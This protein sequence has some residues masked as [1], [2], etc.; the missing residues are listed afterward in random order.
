MEPWTCLKVGEGQVDDAVKAPGAR[1]GGVQGS[2]P[3]GGRHDDDTRV[4]L[5]AVHL[6]QQLID[7]LHALCRCTGDT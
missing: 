3:V 6:C 1:E 7:R 2:R 4:V 5:K